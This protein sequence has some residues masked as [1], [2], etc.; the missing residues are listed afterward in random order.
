MREYIDFK[1]NVKKQ[2]FNEEK[3]KEFIRPFDL[4]K[5]PLIRVK[6]IKDKD[7]NYLLFD[8]HHII[9]DGRTMNIFIKELGKLYKGKSLE[10]IKVQYKDYSEWIRERDMSKQKEYW[11]KE[12][13][14]E[15]PV[16]DIPLDY[17]RPQEQSFKGATIKLSVK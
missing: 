12:F 3:I 16:L 4:G 5:A 8:M 17:K 13:S 6:V 15:I 7:R 11:L 1:I 10:E 9:S 14:E 2:R